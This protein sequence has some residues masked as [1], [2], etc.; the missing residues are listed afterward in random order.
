[1]T[2]SETAASAIVT[3]SAISD[4][5]EDSAA[6]VICSTSAASIMYKRAVW[7]DVAGAVGSAVAVDGDRTVDDRV[8]VGVGVDGGV[9]VGG[10]V[11]VDGV[12]GDGVGMGA[13]A[14][15]GE[16][17]SDIRGSDGIAVSW[18]AINGA[19]WTDVDCSVA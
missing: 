12:V 2:R 19:S 14:G 1:M 16:T 13:C 10:V 3:S 8:G 7:V 17:D 9:R 18:A 6:A 4:R 11:G 5:M 15:E